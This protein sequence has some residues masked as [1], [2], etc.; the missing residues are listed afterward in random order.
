[1][2]FIVGKKDGQGSVSVCIAGIRAQYAGNQ[3]RGA[4]T[5]TSTKATAS[6]RVASEAA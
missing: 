5:Y 6:V 2:F 3:L 1:M 4:G